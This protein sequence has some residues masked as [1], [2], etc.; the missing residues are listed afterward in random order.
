MID[1]KDPS[2]AGWQGSAK[3]SPPT[4]PPPSEGSVT[5]VPPPPPPT[6][7]AAGPSKFSKG[8]RVGD[9]ELVERLSGK[10]KEVDSWRALHPRFGD[11]FVKIP[12]SPFLPTDTAAAGYAPRAALFE[13][14]EE[15]RHRTC[16][17]FSRVVAGDGALVA[18]LEVG[19]V[20]TDRAIRLFIA[21][22][23]HHDAEDE[24]VLLRLDR[25]ARV[26]FVRS[27]LL[28]VRQLHR[29][30]FVHGDLKPDN[31]LI[32]PAEAGLLARLIDIDNSFASGT[33]PD[34]SLLGGDD[35][36]M[37]PER[38]LV[39]E[40]LSPSEQVLTVASDVFS[41]ALTLYK[42]MRGKHLE[43]DGGRGT[44]AQRALGGHTSQ[45][46]GLGIGL[47]R[48]DAVLL[49]CLAEKP[50]RRPSIDLLVAASGVHIVDAVGVSR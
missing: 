1:D 22:R 40:D 17:D 24:K 6:P 27:V 5:S 35:A 50:S 47:P 26:V 13:I 36:W 45:W 37:S 33:R 20:A 32:L 14:F 3:D 49:R 39:Q 29:R 23:W 16:D 43:W 44:A 8:D 12:K 7:V 41:L 42:L 30:G 21:T 15:L 38:F 11:T 34:K 2:S 31:I 19:R 9:H 25:V 28:A 46:D 4:M 18:P 48:L 10:G